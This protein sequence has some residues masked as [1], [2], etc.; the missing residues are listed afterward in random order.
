MS[1]ERITL[2]TLVLVAVAGLASGQQKS[3]PPPACGKC[4]SDCGGKCGI[5]LK[6]HFKSCAGEKQ[7]CAV[8]P[9]TKVYTGN[10][11]QCQCT[12]VCLP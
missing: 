3:C 10:A 4:D 1:L 2:A 9:D 11:Y 8:Q 5:D 7:G 12:T 6:P